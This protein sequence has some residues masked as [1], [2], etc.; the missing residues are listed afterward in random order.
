[1]STWTMIH[2]LLAETELRGIAGFI[3]ETAKKLASL[4]PR[5]SVK[6]KQADESLSFENQIL[7]AAKSMTAAIGTLVKQATETQKEL[8]SKGKMGGEEA[9]WSLDLIAA[10]RLTATATSDLCDGANA[11]VRGEPS[12]AQLV[13][14]SK[15]VAESTRRL[16]EVCAAHGDPNSRTQQGLQS[17]GA[18]VQKA[19]GVLVDAATGALVFQ[20]E[21]PDLVNDASAFNSDLQVELEIQEEILRLE[22]ELIKAKA[23]HHQIQ[24]YNRKLR[25]EEEALEE[26]E[27]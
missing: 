19:A 6:G 20:E 26:E 2:T 5:G 16:L 9:Q 11:A 17:A 1:M 18:A 24:E 7:A 3:E 23:K 8:V 15:G 25:E 4:K 14:A 27:L 10:A 13:S 12:E 21:E 22:K